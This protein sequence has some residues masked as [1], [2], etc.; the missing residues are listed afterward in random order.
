MSGLALLKNGWDKPFGSSL[1]PGAKWLD[2]SDDYTVDFHGTTLVLYNG[3][4]QHGCILFVLPGSTHP[5]MRGSLG[6]RTDFKDR[7]R[8]SETDLAVNIILSCGTLSGVVQYPVTMR[9]A[10]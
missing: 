5:V 9:L 4:R 7:F 6:H 1:A 3:S 10:T 8:S 2:L